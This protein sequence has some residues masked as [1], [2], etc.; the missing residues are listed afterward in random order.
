MNR[1]SIRRRPL[2]PRSHDGLDRGHFG[3]PAR[4]RIRSY[5]RR[6]H[7]QLRTIGHSYLRPGSMKMVF[8][9]ASDHLVEDILNAV[10]QE[11]HLSP[12]SD[13]R[14]R[15]CFGHGNKLKRVPSGRSEAVAA[16]SAC[17]RNC[18][19]AREVQ[20]LAEHRAR[21]LQS[22]RSASAEKIRVK[23]QSLRS[24]RMRSRLAISSARLWYPI[25]SPGATTTTGCQP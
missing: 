24:K 7:G 1:P 21:A 15:L 18:M 16:V 6:S 9:V 4:R 13:F 12:C 2:R 14:S 11:L 19:Q 5:S 17:L 25:K 20:P 3:W 10:R 23:C 8:G 22:L